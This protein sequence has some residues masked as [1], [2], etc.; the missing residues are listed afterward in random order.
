MTHTI[1]DLG[2]LRRPRLLV[3]TARFGLEDYRRER[4]LARLLPGEGLPGPARALALLLAEEAAC[5]AARLRGEATYSVAR[6]VELLIA[7]LGEARLLACAATPPAAASATEAAAPLP[8]ARASG[9][10]AGRG[11]A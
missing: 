5:E 8:R 10:A 3:R 2:A 4:D 6:Q 1:P 7:V 9:M 11:T